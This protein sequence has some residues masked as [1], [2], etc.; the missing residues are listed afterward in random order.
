M[1]VG[2][3]VSENGTTVALLPVWGFKVRFEYKIYMQV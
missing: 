3:T 1:E 2:K